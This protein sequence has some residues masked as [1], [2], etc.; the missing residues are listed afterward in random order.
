MGGRGHLATATYR[1][2]CG[3]TIRAAGDPAARVLILRH[4]LDDG[5][6]G[7]YDDDPLIAR[8]LA[9]DPAVLGEPAIR[10][11]LRGY[12]REP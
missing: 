10:D 9:Q 6:L 11:W 4:G 5:P 3:A 8:V 12:H 7:L 1:C 2:R